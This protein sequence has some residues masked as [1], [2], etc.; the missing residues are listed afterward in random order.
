VRFIQWSD[1][2]S[3]IET[4]GQQ[5]LAIDQAGQDFLKHN[6][7][8]EV[9]VYVVGDFT[10]INP[11]N[12]LEGGWISMPALGLLKQ[13]GYT[14]LFTPGNHDAFDWTVKIDGAQL[15]LKQMQQLKKWGVKILASNLRQKTKAFKTV[16]QASYPLKT[17]EP[18]THVVGLTLPVIMSKSNL[19]E[20]SAQSLFASIEPY[21]DS[22]QRIFPELARQG[23]ENVIFG[24]HQGHE[25]IKR[26]VPIMREVLLNQALDGLR[27]PLIMGGHDHLA[28]SYRY[29]GTHISNGGAYG[30]LS[31]IDITRNGRVRSERV[32]HIPMTIEQ[33]EGIRPELF[34]MSQVRMNPYGIEDVETAPWLTDYHQQITQHL[35]ENEERLGR[36]RGR[37]IADINEHKLHMKSGPSELGAMLSETLVA[38]A[39]RTYFLNNHIPVVAMTNSSSYRLEEKLRRGPLTEYQIRAMYPFNNEASLFQVSGQELTQLYFT[40]REFYANGAAGL[41]SPQLNF[42]VRENGESLEVQHPSGQWTSVNPNQSYYLALDGWLSGHRHGQSYRIQPWFD[43]LQNRQPMATESYQDLLL[44]YLPRIIEA[45]QRQQPIHPP[46]PLVCSGVFH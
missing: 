35:Q 2:H 19:T 14:V 25:K 28:A 26:Q 46:Q 12:T 30:A 29:K 9:I 3:S 32:R 41:H 5:L 27:V 13:R 43:V 44:R 33:V 7:Q 21:K 31:V 17:L 24:I 4:M 45:H 40:L 1:A 36:V 15:F 34:P 16:T 11:S 37:L 6:P 38:W 39:R 8:G 42:S 23:V 20:E 18:L 10:S 22:F